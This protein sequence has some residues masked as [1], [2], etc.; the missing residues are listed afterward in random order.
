[1]Q[2]SDIIN[3]ILSV[4]SFIL[5]FVSIITVILTI[6]QN[7]KMI[8]IMIRPYI[9]IYAELTNFKSQTFYLIIKNSGQSS[10][11]IISFKSEKNLEKY[12]YIQE[13]SIFNHIEGTVLVPGQKIMTVL[14]LDK[15]KNDDIEEFSFEI[16]YESEG[17]KYSEKYR[18][19]YL[20]YRN[21]VQKRI[22][23]ENDETISYVLQNMVERML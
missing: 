19:N 8:E 5:S 23:E 16:E 15:I 20:I 11:K 9:S 21:I 13:K 6:K 2:V 17:I 12:S 3:I 7:S 18:I 14:N 1:M 4:L 10:A 22:C